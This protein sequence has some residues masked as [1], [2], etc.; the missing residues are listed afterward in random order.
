MRAFCA[1]VF[2]VNIIN[3]F[4]EKQDR[5]GGERSKTLCELEKMNKMEYK[6]QQELFGAHDFTCAVKKKRCN[7]ISTFALLSKNDTTNLLTPNLE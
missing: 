6:Q 2:V 4:K 5:Y 1:H 3:Q 7:F